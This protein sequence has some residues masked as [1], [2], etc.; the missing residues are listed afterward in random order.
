MLTR[1]QINQ[2]KLDIADNHP[3]RAR[4][5]FDHIVPVLKVLRRCFKKQPDFKHSLRTAIHREMDIKMPKSEDQL[6]EEPFLIL[7]YGINAYF[8]IMI[9]L[10]GLCA[11]ITVFMIPLYYGYSSNEVNGFKGTSTHILTQFTLGNL[12][13]AGV[14]CY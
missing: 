11:A 9:A 8:D 1:Q 7:G 13:G 6:F 10:A 4:A 14:E 3:L 2:C 12:G 5:K